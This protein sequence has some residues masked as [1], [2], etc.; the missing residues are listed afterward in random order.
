MATSSSSPPARPALRHHAET[1]A[2]RTEPATMTVLSYVRERIV[3]GVIA[4]NSRLR[5]EALATE[6][7]VSR[8]PVRSALAILSAEGLV[9]YSIN[10]GYTVR[11]ITFHDVLDAIEARAVLESRACGLSVDHG[12][13]AE[14]LA[15]L[16][17]MVAHGQAIVDG[18]LW[19]EA[20]E[21]DWYANNRLFHFT[22]VAAS[23]NVVI[24]NALR[25]TLIH[26]IFGDIARLCPAVAQLVPQRHRAIP[27]KPPQ[28]ILKSQADHGHILA[29]ITAEDAP[30][31]ERHMLE[32]VLDTK[33]RLATIAT[34]R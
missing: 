32:H 19:S 11:E 9:S 20:I 15:A 33:H 2:M 28:H 25:M 13:S 26:P 30:L 23:Q 22:I 17:A 10:R 24:R 29:A 8:T 14:G 3:T 5:A 4:A 1:R 16:G 6:L 7:G 27:A 34:R 31:A 12:W 18:G 21:H